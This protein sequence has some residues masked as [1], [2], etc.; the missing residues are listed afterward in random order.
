MEEHDHLM[1]MEQVKSKRMQAVA[2]AQNARDAKTRQFVD[3]KAVADLIK[4]EGE[5]IGQQRVLEKEKDVIINRQLVKEIKEV[6]EK[7]PR[8]AEAKVFRERQQVRKT[9]KEELQEAWEKKIKEDE[10]EQAR[11]MD[12]I[13]QLRTHIVH[14][15]EVKVFDPT[16]SAGL[17]LL[18]EMSLVEMEERLKINQVREKNEEIEKRRHIVAERSIKQAQLAQRIS[19]IK[20]IREAAKTSN[21]EARQQKKLNEKLK[22]E[23]EEQALRIKEVALAEQLMHEREERKKEM[24]TL[25][26]EEERRKKNQMF[27]GAATH[28]VEETHYDQLLLG[29]ER[30][31]RMRK[32]KA[33]SAAL[34][35]EQT[36]I[37]ARKVVEKETRTKVAA[38]KKLYK[39][40]DDEI[41]EKRADLLTK[42]KSEVANKKY[43]FAVTRQ[44]E[45]EIKAMT[46]D[47]NV[48]AQS[49]N[50]M[51]LTLA[52]THAARQSKKNV[53][54]MLTE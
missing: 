16:T 25:M 31:A 54:A 53:V 32:E 28:Q 30:E 11:K 2:S 20:R 15:P 23:R 13:R 18:D 10:V 14:K 7:A 4:E 44:K 50:D 5:L 33:Q 27:Q 51:S 26:D 22:A 6:E 43:A 1:K 46:V 29:R 21:M 42:Q 19:N 36:K 41:K 17:G 34:I 39:A 12:K 40:K 45:K 47:R 24:G 52:K 8:K 38:K 3:N 37:T 35:Y 48:Y 9:Q 49:I